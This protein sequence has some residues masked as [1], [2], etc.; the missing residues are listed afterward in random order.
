MIHFFLFFA[1]LSS[2]EQ[3]MLYLCNQFQIRKNDSDNQQRSDNE[4]T[5]EDTHSPFAGSGCTDVLRRHS[6]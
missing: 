3:K 6:G 5:H 1:V 4:Y 2:S